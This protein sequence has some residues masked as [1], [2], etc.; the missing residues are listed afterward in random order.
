MERWFAGLGARAD[1]GGDRVVLGARRVCW[2]GGS[3]SVQ[4]LELGLQVGFQAG[5]VVALEGA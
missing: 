5:A 2:C 1:P 3:V 4:F